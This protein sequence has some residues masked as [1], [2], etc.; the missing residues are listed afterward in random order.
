MSKVS[1]TKEILEIDF[2]TVRYVSNFTTVI[3]VTNH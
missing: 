3:M 2:T 1:H